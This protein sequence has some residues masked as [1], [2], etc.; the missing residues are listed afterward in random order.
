[1]KLSVVIITF[2]CEKI[3][4]DA[5]NSAS[6][7]DEILVLDSGSDDKTVERA[8]NLGAKIRYQ[9]WLGFGR[10]KQRAIELAKNDW[11]FVLDSDERI[12]K[13]LQKEIVSVLK[14]P[15]FVAYTVPRLNNFFGKFI[16]HGGF[17]P[18]RNVR[19]FDRRYAN[20]TDDKVHE[21]IITNGRMGHLK[22]PM[23]HYAYD[24]IEEFINKQNRYS[25]LG[26]RRNR[27]KAVFS[28]F[29]TFFRIYIL[30]L[31]FLDGWRGF[32]VAKL[33][34]QYTFWKYIK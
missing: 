24:T 22:K 32:I 12:T 30:K 28:P 13:A 4:T 19:L 31:G 3:I 5:I 29:W 34:S 21:K 20:F 23:I 26:A 17:F 1:M 14:K 11:V 8:G 33:Y 6:F 9:K 15:S 27:F 7:A 25:T 16:R 10:Q 18:D 2:N